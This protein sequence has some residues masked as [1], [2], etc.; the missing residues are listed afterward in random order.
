MKHVLV[1]GGAGFI[2]GHLTESLLQD[3]CKVTVID[4]LST[5]SLQNLKAVEHHPDL[6][7]IEA[8]ILTFDAMDSVV[9]E[10]DAV[11]H[12]AAA[13]GVELV[14]DHPAETIVTN[15]HGTE[16]ILL[17]AA[18][19]GKRTIIASTSEVYGKSTK[20]FF[21]ESDDLLIGPPQFSRWGYA[22]SKL[23]D[24]FY[25]M[26][27]CQSANLPGTVVR[28]F[29]TVGPRQSGQYGM[30]LP[31]FVRAAL[32][33]EPIR[34]YGSGEQCRCF[35]HVKDTIR[36]V[37]GLL[38]KPETIGKV[39]NIGSQRSISI[40]ELASLVKQ[41]LNSTSEIVKV[42]Y[43]VAYGSGFEEMLRRRPDTNAIQSLL[44]WKPELSLEQIIRDVAE[45]ER[46][47]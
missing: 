23:L 33:G 39:Y 14:V 38:D 32:K 47:C 27:L 26:A 20:D 16:K 34:V 42:P 15:V 18:K 22:C 17:P 6:R 44:G 30:V 11:V 37:R 46:H 29:N 9:A 24:E 43:S 28:F 4:N 21:N 8:D 1:T 25:L 3:G 2:G 10:V 7:F 19:Y 13:V 31:R 35:C 36:A 5:G 12:L 45:F 40:G 41:E